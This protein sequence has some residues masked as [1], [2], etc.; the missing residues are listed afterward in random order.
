M[1]FRN[2]IY[3]LLQPLASPK[4]KRLPEGKQA[5]KKDTHPFFAKKQRQMGFLAILYSLFILA[6]FLKTVDKYRV[7]CY[8]DTAMQQNIDSVAT[9]RVAGLF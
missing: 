9:R 7:I 1:L 4:K 8:I 2:R 5:Q 3:I 6:F